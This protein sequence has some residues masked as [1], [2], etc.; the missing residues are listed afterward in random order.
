MK[1]SN[2]S[3]S[4]ITYFKSNPG[5]AVVII[6]LII[7]GIVAMGALV[8]PELFW[9][10]F[11][12]KYYWGP[13]AA[14]AENKA[15][16]G[17]TEGY[18]MVSTLTYGIILAAAIFVIYRLILVLGINLDKWF[19]IAVIPFIMFGGF[20]R[21]L[22]DAVL[23]NHPLVYLFISPL[24][25]V[26]T[27]LA[28]LA[29]LITA[30]RISTYNIAKA[31][32]YR[33]VIILIAVTLAVINFCFI[34]IYFNSDWT[35][36]QINPAFTIAA[37]IAGFIV[38]FFYIHKNPD[39]TIPMPLAFGI[40]GI[41]LLS[42]PAA[43]VGAWYSS[44]SDWITAYYTSSFE[45]TVIFRPFVIPV[46]LGLSIM[47]TAIWA[48][49]S[50]LISTRTKWYQAKFFRSGTNLALVFGQF[51]DA[52]ATFIAIDYYN[53]WE[54][55]VVPGFLIGVLNT[56]AVMFILKVAALIF[57]IY[58]LDIAL[59]K[60]LEKHSQIVWLVKLAVLVLGLAPGTR[61]MLRLAMGV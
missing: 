41:V 31:E 15:V 47:G 16:D 10:N 25:Y 5:K 48:A 29:L 34:L 32:P 13:I 23:F 46:I 1:A 45:D 55:H 58:I 44:P 33:L 11:I 9:D 37:S 18:N 50:R 17:I 24:I 51:T 28:A 22:E 57:A 60:E 7:F 30:H 43:A 2:S 49:A 40:F 38:I 39:E 3:M 26:V 14:D 4:V 21:A 42:Y 12:W 20:A 35:N 19:F 6:S 36:Y 56:G 54:K 61:D 8:L 53:Y 52:S 59:K 27:G